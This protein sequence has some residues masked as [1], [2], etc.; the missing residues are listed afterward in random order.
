MKILP[1]AKALTWARKWWFN[2]ILPDWDAHSNPFKKKVLILIHASR[3]LWRIQQNLSAKMKLREE[4][5]RHENLTYKRK[6][7]S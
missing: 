7:T 2:S 3:S 4:K 1:T 6:E 5:M